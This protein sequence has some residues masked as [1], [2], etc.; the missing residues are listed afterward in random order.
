M[1][2]G[3]DAYLEGRQE[4]RLHPDEC[5]NPKCIGCFCDTC[6][7]RMTPEQVND[8]SGGICPFCKTKL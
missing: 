8:L 6:V 7:A 5:G 3:L 2:S 4:P 1:I